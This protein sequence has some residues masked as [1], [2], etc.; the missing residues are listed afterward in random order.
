MVKLNYWGTPDLTSSARLGGGAGKRTQKHTHT[1]THECTAPAGCRSCT[2]M[3]CVAQAH[4]HCFKPT[5]SL[6]QTDLCSRYLS[7]P[8][9]KQSWKTTQGLHSHLSK[10]RCFTYAKWFAQEGMTLLSPLRLAFSKSML[11]TWVTTISWQVME[12]KRSSNKT[13]SRIYKY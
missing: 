9:V 1:N 13:A 2:G 4:L 5:P 6:A 7:K 12:P 10:E 3:H 8:A 11:C